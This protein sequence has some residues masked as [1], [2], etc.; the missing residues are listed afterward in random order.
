MTLVRSPRNVDA[1]YDL[2]TSKSHLPYQEGTSP[3]NQSSLLKDVIGVV[4]VSPCLLGLLL[5]VDSY[6]K[7]D[8]K[9]TLGG[10]IEFT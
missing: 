4:E 6:R 9:S 3:L 1:R 7:N 8:L 2:R 5:P 10:W